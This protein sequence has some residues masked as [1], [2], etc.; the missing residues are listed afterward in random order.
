MDVASFSS[1]GPSADGRRR[2]DLLAPGTHVSGGVAQEAGQRATPPADPLG[3]ALSCFDASG[4]CEGHR[5]AFFPR[6][7]SS[8]CAPPDAGR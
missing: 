8:G 6:P 5:S 4:V 2:P 3:D 1:R 7:P